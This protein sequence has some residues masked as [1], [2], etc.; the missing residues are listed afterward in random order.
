MTNTM[1]IDLHEVVSLSVPRAVELWLRMPTAAADRAEQLSDLDEAETTALAG[2]LTPETAGELLSDMDAATSAQ[3]LAAIDPSDAA[4]LVA[5]L[6]PGVT[7]RALREIAPAARREI[8]AGMDDSAAETIIGYLAWP[9]DSAGTWLRAR[10]ATVRP[11]ASVTDALAGLS[12]AVGEG[13]GYHY[14][15]VTDPDGTLRGVVSFK[16]F[17]LAPADMPVRDVMKTDVVQV[18]PYDDQETAAR[19]LARHKFAVLPVVDGGTLLG[20]VTRADMTDVLETESTEDAERQGGSAPLEMPYLQAS[21]FQLWRKRIGWIAILFLAEMYTGTVM[22]A[23]EVELETVVAL[24]FFV[25]LLIGTGGNTGTQVTS[26]LIRALATGQANLRDLPRIVG[27]EAV[28]G[29]M[30]GVTMAVLGWVRAWT[31][32]VG[33]EVGLTV[34]VSIAAIVVWSSLLA[35]VLPL[36][37][38]KL[39]LDPAVVSSP[40]ITTLVDG[41]GLVIYF[42]V[43]KVFIS[44]LG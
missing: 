13:E 44:A 5:L 24:A 29:L 38:K 15:Y 28:T 18:S 30:I 25:P 34:A 41:T 26:T 4:G 27:K 31:L 36:L 8:I 17:A 12:A 2:L 32:G 14:V 22:R 16:A 7:A 1:L 11:D 42:T 37:L 40:L 3:F 19:T 35:A 39:R 21:P 9:E 6:D 10:R 33:P 43:A 20:V 23:F